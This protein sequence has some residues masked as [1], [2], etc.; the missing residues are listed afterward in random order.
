MSPFGPLDELR[1]KPIP[2]QDSARTAR[3]GFRALPIDRGH[4][5]AGEPLVEIAAEGIAGENHYHSTRNPP[6]WTR[7]AGSIAEL[8]LR[9][10]V[11]VKLARVNRHLQVAG[12]QL[13]VFDAWRP[14]AVQ[15][16]FHD[17]WMPRE[18]QRRHK[19][20]SG[21]ALLR[22][23]ERYWA[24]P[25]RD[26]SSPAPHATGAAV[27]LT[28]RWRGGDPLWMGSIFDD[29]TDSAHRDRFER[30]A[31]RAAS[32]SDEEARANRRLLHWVMTKE[33]FAGHPEEWWHFSWGDQLWSALTGAGP[34]FYGLIEP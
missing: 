23:V 19:E 12:L 31:E 1:T 26:E 4:M 25:T 34:A 30:A 14:R 15:A 7:I 17:V 6:Y 5:L 13:F 8:Y 33:G 24:A 21:A 18:L 11:T 16:Y 22:E 3:T 27:D 2:D 32:F 29:A 20:L 10:S 9:R 28:L